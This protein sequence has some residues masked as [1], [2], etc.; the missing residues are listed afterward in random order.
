MASE[1]RTGREAKK[2]VCAL[3]RGEKEGLI[4]TLANI[5]TNVSRRDL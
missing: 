3:G 5:K 1:L 2:E 4:K